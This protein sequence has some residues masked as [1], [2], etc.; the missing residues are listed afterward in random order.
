M[1]VSVRFRTAV[2]TERFQS[3]P[4]Y[5]RRQTRSMSRSRPSSGLWAVKRS[6]RFACRSRI[7]RIA[8]ARFS[9]SKP[10]KASHCYLSTIL[11]ACTKQV[12]SYV[13]SESLEV[14]FVLE[15]VKQ[16]AKLSPNEYYDYITTG[17]YPVLF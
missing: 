7:K 11:A 15:T 1:S 16:L 10:A 8:L 13:L 5:G 9:S 14:D 2:R 17:E 4:G 3:L 6:R 12:L